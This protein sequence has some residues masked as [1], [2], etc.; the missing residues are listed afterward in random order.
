MRSQTQNKKGSFD[1]HQWINHVG[2]AYGPCGRAFTNEALV[3]SI[4]IL[5][6]L[7]MRVRVGWARGGAGHVCAHNRFPQEELRL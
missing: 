5:M 4:S 1:A 3:P 7:M 6:E 2:C